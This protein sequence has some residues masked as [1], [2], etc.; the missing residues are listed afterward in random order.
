MGKVIVDIVD[1]ICFIGSVLMGCKIVVVVVVWFILVFFEL[2][3]KDFVIVFEDVDLE[4]F[5]DVILRS[6][7]GVMG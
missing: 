2:G 3:G 5:I 4:I 1:V 6:C 7:V